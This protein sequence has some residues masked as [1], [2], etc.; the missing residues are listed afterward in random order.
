MFARHHLGASAAWFKADIMRAS[1]LGILMVLSA[2]AASPRGSALRQ[3]APRFQPLEVILSSAEAHS[4]T[5]GLVPIPATVIDVGV[6]KNV[7]YQSFSNGTVEVN[8]YGDPQHLVAIEAGTKDENAQ[9]KGCLITFVARQA[10][11]AADREQAFGAVRGRTVTPSGLTIETTDASEPDAYGAWWFSLEAME[12][13]SRATASAEEIA[14]LSSPSHEWDVP[15]PPA[16]EG[17]R[18]SSNSVSVAAPSGYLSTQ[19]YR[20][21]SSYRPTGGS[22]YV[23]GY[24]RKNG[25][26]VRPHTRRR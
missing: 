16:Y 23:H 10:R 11:D 18:T 5:R 15:P 20:A 13:L 21:S 12:Q 22:V 24:T 2:C 1:V 26:Y 9:L 25:T 19:R 14:A 6:F 8:A 4:C 3:H 7:P 17:A